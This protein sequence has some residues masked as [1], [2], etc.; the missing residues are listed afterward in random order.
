MGV[1]ACIGAF[2]AFHAVGWSNQPDGWLTG[3]HSLAGN[4]RH[5]T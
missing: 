4:L 1:P 2:I 5:E 3:P